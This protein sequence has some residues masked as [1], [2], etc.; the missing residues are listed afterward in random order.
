MIKQKIIS[1]DTTTNPLII[2][3]VRF[4]QN[5]ALS[6]DT[7][8]NI[9]KCK[10]TRYTTFNHISLTMKDKHYKD[11]PVYPNKITAHFIKKNR[12][13]KPYKQTIQ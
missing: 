8:A 4:I 13:N 3:Y 5:A 12:T 2:K 6:Q 1:L 7:L 9:K 10:N 11:E